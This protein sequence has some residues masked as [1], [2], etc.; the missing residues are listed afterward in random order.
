MLRENDSVAV[1]QGLGVVAACESGSG[2]VWPCP[3]PP[4]ECGPLC[5]AAEAWGGE[6][7]RELGVHGVVPDSKP[8]LPSS[9][10]EVQ[11]PPPVGE[12][13]QVKLVLPEEPP[14]VAVA[15]TE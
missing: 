10:A 12:I 2:G 13:V 14:L 11:P 6:I 4:A 8:A 5:G 1:G 7:T 3:S 15:V 9:C